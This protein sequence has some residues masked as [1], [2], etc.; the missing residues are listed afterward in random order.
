MKKFKGSGL[1]IMTIIS[2]GIAGLI[3]VSLA[4]VNH[5]TFSG[6]NSSQIAMQAQQYAESKME[7]LKNNSYDNLIAQKK[8]KI[9]FS[10]GYYDEVLVSSQTGPNNK[11]Y[12]DVTVNVFKD[13][14][15]ISSCSLNRRF[16]KT[17]EKSNDF[18]KSY[19]IDKNGSISFIAPSDISKISVLCTTNWKQ[20]WGA[21]NSGVNTV[22]IGNFGKLVMDIQVSR[23]GSKGHGWQYPGAKS[24]A[25]S[26]NVDIAEGSNI[27][28]STN[29]TGG[30]EVENTAILLV[31]S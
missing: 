30:W 2:A 23:G 12:K 8:E 11:V 16:Y 20:N 10:N 17:S 18:C 3:A 26:F 6:L 31:F 4:K 27:T 13:E 25:G 14:N 21:S 29:S 22:N 15:S 24:A 28:I 9:E 1:L 5:L 19:L 7:L